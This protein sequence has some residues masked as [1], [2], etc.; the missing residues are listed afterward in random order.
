MPGVSRCY[1]YVAA[2]GVASCVLVEGLA[3]RVLRA[4]KKFEVP[5]RPV[6]RL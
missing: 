4:R 5:V 1:G 3:W 2:A 6:D